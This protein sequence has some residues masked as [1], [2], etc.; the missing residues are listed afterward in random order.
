MLIKGVPNSNSTCKGLTKQ[1]TSMADII[2]D[3]TEIRDAYLAINQTN[4]R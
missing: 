3:I 2:I 1:T 4:G